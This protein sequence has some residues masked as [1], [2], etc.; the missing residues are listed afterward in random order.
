MD[1]VGLWLESIGLQQ[2]VEV[3]KDNDMDGEILSLSS[4]D[5]LEKLVPS[6]GHRIKILKARDLMLGSSA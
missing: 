2:Y 3:F 4:R 1:E 6:L 5:D